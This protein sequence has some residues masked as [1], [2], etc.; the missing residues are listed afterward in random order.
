MK[1]LH[2]GGCHCGAVRYEV[3]LD[4][5]QGTF[6]CNCSICAKARLW[7]AVV[8]PEDFRLLS[9]KS[10]LTEYVFGSRRIHHLF[11]RV[12][13]I[14]SFGWGE[15]EDS[16]GRF[17]AVHVSCLDEVKPEDLVNVP[18]TYVDGRHDRWHGAPEEIRHL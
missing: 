8:P 13:G 3:A 5:A 4:L 2:R 9:G 10:M 7:L 15:S 17:Y 18:V 14:R 12:C 16:G 6:K 11:C 1:K